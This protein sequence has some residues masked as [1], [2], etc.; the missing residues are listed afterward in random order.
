MARAKFVRALNHLL[1]VNISDVFNLGNGSGYSVAEVVA[2]VER[3][4]GCVVP[5]ING[6][7]REGDP[8]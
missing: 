6:A 5:V 2:A 4:T 3:V 7:R 8:A 1:E